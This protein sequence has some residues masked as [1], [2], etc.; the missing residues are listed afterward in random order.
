MPSSVVL[1]FSLGT[2]IG[3]V[4]FVVLKLSYKYSG[5]SNTFFASS[6]RR[7]GNNSGDIIIYALG[8]FPSIMVAIH[9]NGKVSTPKFS[10]LPKR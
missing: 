5:L 2:C 4:G 10:L 8:N 6:W 9:Q 3:I 7:M 1:D